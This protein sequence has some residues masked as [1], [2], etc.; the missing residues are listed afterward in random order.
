MRA[1]RAG[2]RIDRL[3]LVA[4]PPALIAPAGIAASGLRTLVLVGEYDTIAPAPELAAAFESAAQVELHVIPHAD[5]FFLE[6][7]AEIGRRAAEWLGAG[8]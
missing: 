3:L 6:G 4:P 2:A 7:L 5:H 8:S 1:A